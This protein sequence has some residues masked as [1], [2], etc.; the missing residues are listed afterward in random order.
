[1]TQELASSTLTAQGCKPVFLDRQSPEATCFDWKCSPGT[2]AVRHM[3][4]SFALEAYML[5]EV[6]MQVRHEELPCTK[7]TQLLYY[8]LSV[9]K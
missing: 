3:T 8:D 7:T 5:S 2:L 6:E 4:Q 1:M 9:T